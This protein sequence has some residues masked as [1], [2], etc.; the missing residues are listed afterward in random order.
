MIVVGTPQWSQRVDEAAV[1]P[2]VGYQNIMYTLH[3]YAATHKTQLREK[4]LGAV[5]RG[6]PIFVT[7]YGICDASGNGALDLKQADQW[8][9]LLDCYKISFVAW[10]LS[11][12]DESSAILRPECSKDSDFTDQDL[13]ESGLWLKNMLSVHIKYGSNL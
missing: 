1:D 8:I 6:L 10:N 2:I 13:S 7:E 12:K 3:F 5:E 9:S 4:L 11:N